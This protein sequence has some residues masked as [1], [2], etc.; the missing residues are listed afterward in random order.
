MDIS[1]RGL[2]IELLQHIVDILYDDRDLAALKACSRVNHLLYSLSQMHLLRDVVLHQEDI[3]AYPTTASPPTIITP[4]F[5]PALHF[6]QFLDDSPHIAPYIHSLAIECD[7]LPTNA[8]R[9][10]HLVHW[11]ESDT[12]TGLATVVA[13]LTNL[14]RFSVK[15]KSTLTEHK[16]RTWTRVSGGLRA[17]LLASFSSSITTE[18]DLTGV[19]QFPACLFRYCTSLN[20]LSIGSLF[21]NTDEL[22]SGE[23][24]STPCRLQY[25]HLDDTLD[26]EGLTVWFS[27]PGCPLDI[28]HL[29]HLSVCPNGP[30]GM[31]N[32][33]LLSSCAKSVTHIHLHT[34][35]A[36]VLTSYNTLNYT[37]QHSGSPHPDLRGFE[38]LKSLTID[39]EFTVRIFHHRT[40]VDYFTNPFPW[41][42]DL[43]K[44]MSDCPP[45]AMGL[46]KLTLN[47]TF[48][49]FPHELMRLLQG[50]WQKLEQRLENFPNFSTVE[51]HAK[52]LE[53]IAFV[54]LR[55]DEHLS[56]MADRGRLVFT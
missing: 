25:L 47:L 40:L 49:D 32:L 48:I 22:S 28:A 26:F 11:L 27:S 21:C 42:T 46:T 53:E 30:T 24:K 52:G 50:N 10:Y 34:E 20:H 17:G 18:I 2:P 35:H 41:I 54:K 5:N 3:Y 56:R 36:E 45:L 6:L 14:R 8:R 31:G 1:Y 55:Q 12:G 16:P 19:S 51:M 44:N 13:R 7:W 4:V 23:V 33:S 38:A 37:L 39:A 9:G 29:E 15:G 43:L